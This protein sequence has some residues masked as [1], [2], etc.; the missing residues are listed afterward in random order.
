LQLRNDKSTLIVIAGRQIAAKE[1][2]EILLIG[3]KQ[4]IPD[5]LGIDEVID[6]TED[7]GVIRIVPWG[8]GKW[9]F[10]RSRLLTRLVNDYANSNLYLG[11][12][13][14]RPWF[15][16]QP[17]H[18]SE[19]ARQDVYNLPGTDP[20]PFPGEH[21]KVGGYGFEID[22]DPGERPATNLARAIRGLGFQP[23]TYGRRENAMS[24]VRNQ[25]RMQI[26][27]RRK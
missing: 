7:Q 5:G 18:F 4:D 25:V 13:S 1:G 10:A 24:F 9:L 22:F 2:L 14:A 23:K 3:S 27:K 8:A 17:S 19:A 6:R 12:E 26:R 16:P 15:W 21:T 20:L 11:D